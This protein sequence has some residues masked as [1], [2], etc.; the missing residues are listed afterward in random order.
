VTYWRGFAAD[1]GAIRFNTPEAGVVRVSGLGGAERIYDVTDAGAPRVITDFA[2]SAGELVFRASRAGGF[3]VDASPD[4]PVF[5]LRP[6]SSLRSGTNRADYLL[7][8]HRDFRNASELLAAHREAEELAVLV[9]DADVVYDEFNF[10]FESPDAIRLFFAYAQESYEPPAARFA[11]IMGDASV[12]PKGHQGFRTNFVVTKFIRTLE[13]YVASENYL[14]AFRGDDD[15]PDIS[16]GRL[17]VSTAD[18]ADAVVSKIIA[19]EGALSGDWS[20]ASIFVSDVPDCFDF[21][22]SGTG[23]LLPLVPAGG[24]VTH[25]KASE[26]NATERVLSSWNE[27]AAMVHYTGHGGACQ[28]GGSLDNP[29]FH[30]T[31]ARELVNEGRLPFVLISNCASANFTLPLPQHECIAEDLLENPAG[32]A[33]AVFA[34]TGL[35]TPYGQIE[36]NA[37]VLRLYYNN[38]SLRAGELTDAGKVHIATLGSHYTEIIRTWAL[39][40]DP[41]TH[42]K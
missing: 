26:G 13:A 28:W 31:N 8:T 34:S 6:P 19:Y 1:G 18:E 37:E 23:R 3:A 22:T 2:Y 30:V 39:I 24:A 33:I 7:I 29:I 25:V 10:G 11:L 14:C 40:G 12:D 27:G 42:L 38:P 17:A 9:A 35:T 36:M 32:G 41:A 21:E 4:A 5:E 16:L 15:L 20:K